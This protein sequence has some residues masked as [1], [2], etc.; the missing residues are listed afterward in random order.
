MK[1][2]ALPEIRQRLIDGGSEVIG[3]SPE[4]ADR[5]LQTETARWGAVVRAAKISAE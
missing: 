1:V 3:N 5:F 2:L 4:A